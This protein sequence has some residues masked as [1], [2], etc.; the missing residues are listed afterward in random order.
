MAEMREDTEGKAR[1]ER[2]EQLVRPPDPGEGLN[3]SG[4]LSDVPEE[5]SR[6]ELS[7][8]KACR[9]EREMLTCS[10]P[11]PY[12]SSGRRDQQVFGSNE[13]EMRRTG[14]KGHPSS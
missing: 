13:N 3:E 2:Y 11:T 7:A 14:C 8:S 10:W 5:L 1:T 9:G 6:Q 12:L 4:L